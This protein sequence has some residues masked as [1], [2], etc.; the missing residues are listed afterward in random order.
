[1]KVLVCGGRGYFDRRKI[2]DTL[3]KINAEFPIDCIVQGEATGADTIGKAWAVLR[4]I[5]HRDYPADWVEHGRFY[6]GRIRNKQ[7]LDEESPDLVVAFEGD[8]GT[9]NMVMQ[10]TQAGVNVVRIDP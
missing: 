10:A 9:A 5:E 4:R 1:M 2:F 6:A 7:M 3:D 8:N